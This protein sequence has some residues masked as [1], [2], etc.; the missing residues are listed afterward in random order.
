MCNNRLCGVVSFGYKCAEP[1]YPGVYTKVETYAEWIRTEANKFE[2]QDS[3][4]GN[5]RGGTALTILIMMTSFIGKN[6]S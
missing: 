5:I 1:K 4:A 3:A 2:V 6:I